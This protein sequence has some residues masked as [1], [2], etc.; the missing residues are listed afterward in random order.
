MGIHFQKV[1]SIFPLKIK[2]LKTVYRW[3]TKKRRH[4]KLSLNL[5]YFVNTH[6][7]TM[8]QNT[9]GKNNVFVKGLDYLLYSYSIAIYTP[10]IFKQL[11]RKTRDDNVLSE[12]CR[13]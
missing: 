13:V 1:L 8:P 12:T 11:M 2:P 6:L 3:E 7:T 5:E 4:G 9:L 10:K